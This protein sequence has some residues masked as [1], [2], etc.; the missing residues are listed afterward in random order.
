MS[1]LTWFKQY[2]VQS[3]DFTLKIKQEVLEENVE[4]HCSLK[5][6]FEDGS[7]N[8]LNLSLSC[9]TGDK[10]L[11]FI[12]LNPLRLVSERNLLVR[13]TNNMLEDA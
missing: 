3:V 2:T 12:L 10:K 11:Q 13:Q 6:Y 5:T 4:V 7:I 9:T 1:T 8:V